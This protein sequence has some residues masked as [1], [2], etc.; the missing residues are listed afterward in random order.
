MHLLGHLGG[1]AV[2][3]GRVCFFVCLFAVL[4]R[5][6]LLRDL[7]R[8][9]RYFPIACSVFRLIGDDVCMCVPWFVCVCLCVCNACVLFCKER[10]LALFTWNLCAASNLLET[11][12]TL[13]QYYQH[14][15]VLLLVSSV[16]PSV[17]VV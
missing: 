4:E 8:D 3:L 1:T 7:L 13:Q 16:E 2:A 9:G 6:F 10:L 11:T 17:L 15:A 5:N 14:T 12:S